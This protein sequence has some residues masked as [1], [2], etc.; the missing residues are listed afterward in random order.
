MALIIKNL[1][2]SSSVSTTGQ[3]PKIAAP[4][5][6]ENVSSKYSCLFAKDTYY[7]LCEAPI[8]TATSAAASV[9]VSSIRLTN[10][11]TTATVAVDLMFARST[12]VVGTSGSVKLPL[13]PPST[14]LPAGFTLIDD[15]EVHLEPGDSIVAKANTA[16]SIKFIISAVQRELA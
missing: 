7:V 10:V 12:S 5:S 2:S 16:N 9:I 15:I 13:I 4:G 11:S 14:Q 3:E 6:N 1:S 8:A